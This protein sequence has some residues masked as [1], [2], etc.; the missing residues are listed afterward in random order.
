MSTSNYVAN[1]QDYS[2]AHYCL[3]APFDPPEAFPEF[4]FIK[5]INKDNCLYG[6]IR[7]L[8]I[9][10]G[11]DENNIGTR[12][13]NPF[14]EM[15]RPGQR[16]II[17]PNLVTH[18]HILGEQALFSSIIHGSI[19]RP[20]IDYIYLALKG[21]GAIVIADNPVEGADFDQ[22]MTFTGIQAMTDELNERGYNILILL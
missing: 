11:L 19:L 2:I 10:L 18:E 6:M 17:K 13:W 16:I 8:F 1:V 20:I 4:D 22:L 12:H 9:E 5:K 7:N 14:K 15:I 3:D 21:E